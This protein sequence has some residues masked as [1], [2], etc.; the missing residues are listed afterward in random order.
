MQPGEVDLGWP[1]VLPSWTIA[2]RFGR[3]A[4]RTSES[5]VVTCVTARSLTATRSPRAS[6][7]SNLT[8]SDRTGVSALARP[9]REAWTQV[10]PAWTP[11]LGAK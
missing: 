5:P 8:A 7:C 4:P 6:R 10:S 9:Y 2:E 11:A 1:E 3:R